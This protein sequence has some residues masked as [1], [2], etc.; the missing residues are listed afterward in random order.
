MTLTSRLRFALFALFLLPIATTLA[1]GPDLAIYTGFAGGTQAA[2][3]AAVLSGDLGKKLGRPVAF[4]AQAGDAQRIALKSV[5]AEVPGQRRL[6]Y[7]GAS[8]EL[9]LSGLKQIATIGWHSLPAL[10][11]AVYGNK[12]MTDAEVA[13][14]REAIST[15]VTSGKLPHVSAQMRAAT[16]QEIPVPIASSVQEKVKKH[17]CTAEMDALAAADVPPEQKKLLGFFRQFN[18]TTMGRYATAGAVSRAH[19]HGQTGID[20]MNGEE[21][22][23]SACLLKALADDTNET[24]LTPYAQEGYALRLLAGKGVPR[25]RAQA[26]QYLERAAYKWFYPS[27][28]MHLGEIHLADKRTP[29][30]REKAIGYFERRMSGFVGEVL[31]GWSAS[32]WETAIPIMFNHYMPSKGPQD[33]E[34]AEWLY[35]RLVGRDHNAP[36]YA[37]YLKRIPGL[38]EKLRAERLAEIAADEAARAAARDQS[39]NKHCIYYANGFTSCKSY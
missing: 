6:F 34:Q 8:Q 37:S 28:L 21:S 4:I 5:L 19:L 18:D 35:R 36:A 26:I 11:F 39:T 3:S 25:D 23:V 2:Q 38:K 7:A 31:G 14:L 33:Y 13:E 10:S 32:P 17:Y 29:G 30:S 12:S 27:A 16:P 9:D 20:Y 1:A 24:P 15:I 22:A